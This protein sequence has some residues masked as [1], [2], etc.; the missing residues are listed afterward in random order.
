M[1]HTILNLSLHNTKAINIITKNSATERNDF[2]LSLMIMLQISTIFSHWI[3]VLFKHTL[4]VISTILCMMICDI[5][6]IMYMYCYDWHKLFLMLKTL[7]CPNASCYN[8]WYF[9]LHS[10]NSSSSSD[11]KARRFS[12]V[13]RDLVDFWKPFI[14]VLWLGSALTWPFCRSFFFLLKIFTSSWSSSKIPARKI[15]ISINSVSPRYSTLE[16]KNYRYS[17]NTMK[18]NNH[19]KSMSLAESTSKIKLKYMHV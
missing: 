15:M 8:Y 19:L 4:L 2:G 5:K 11:N 17:K 16:I 3:Y 6:L 12:S 10:Y 14:I 1:K 9:P 7:F 13:Y 18:I